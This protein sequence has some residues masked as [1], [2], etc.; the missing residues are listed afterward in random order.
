MSS[1]LELTAAVDSMKADFEK[2]KDKVEEMV[3]ICDASQSLALKYLT[4]LREIKALVD[5]ENPDSVKIICLYFEGI[6]LED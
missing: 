2:Y 5:I 1:E 4:N 3:S 6:N